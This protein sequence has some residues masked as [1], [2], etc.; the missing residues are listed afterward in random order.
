MP[1][2]ERDAAAFA[3]WWDTYLNSTDPRRVAKD[4]WHAALASVKSTHIQA[5]KDFVDRVNARAEAD[6]LRGNPLTGAHYRAIQKEVEALD[7][8]GSVV[9]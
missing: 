6:V 3:A 8:S 1:D 2:Q 7:A 5:V 4:A 9:K